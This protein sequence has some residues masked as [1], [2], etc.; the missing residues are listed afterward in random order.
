MWCTVAAVTE[1]DVELVAGAVTA[2]TRANYASAPLMW[3][4]YGRD[5]PAGYSLHD[6]F[7][8]TYS[9]SEQALT[10]CRFLSWMVEK[11]AVRPS[12]A[13][14]L[15]T[16]L[17]FHFI[18]HYHSIAM[19]SDPA[20]V[21][22]KRTMAQAHPVGRWASRPH[23][24]APL[25]FIEEFIV[26]MRERYWAA[27]TATLFMKMQYIAAAFMNVFDRRPGEVAYQGKNKADHRFCWE[28]LVLEL[29]YPDDGGVLAEVLIIKEYLAL[30]NP[31]WNWCVLQNV[32]R[33]C[34]GVMLMGS[35]S[36]LITVRFRCLS[37][38]TISWNGF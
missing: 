25:P 37:S 32:L 17:R 2:G 29:K 10:L 33:R 15:F 24:E 11:Q 35:L 36:L 26:Q 31:N 23:G 7:L 28:D 27:H 1:R 9:P 6:P 34:P 21:M 12:V 22:A 19:F 3:A 16:G 5:S 13:I 20:L 8:S 38:S 14:R 18:T 4:A 30:P